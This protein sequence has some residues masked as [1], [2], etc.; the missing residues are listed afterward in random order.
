MFDFDTCSIFFEN[1]YL[2]FRTCISLLIHVFPL[3]NPYKIIY[4]ILIVSY[5]DL[6]T[7]LGLGRSTRRSTVPISGQDG[8]PHDRLNFWQRSVHVC[9]H[10]RSTDR[11]TA[12]PCGRL[13]GRPTNG[14]RQTARKAVMARFQIFVF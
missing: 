14:D 8:R 5:I 1:L 9:A 11:S 10:S 4:K 3:Q 12:L 13:I 6:G 7:V 2:S